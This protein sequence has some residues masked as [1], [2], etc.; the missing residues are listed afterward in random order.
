M[1][2]GILS[3]WASSHTYPLLSEA[4]AV[5]KLTKMGHFIPVSS[6]ASP[7]QTAQLHFQHWWKL[8]GV[9]QNYGLREGSPFKPALPTSATHQAL[10]TAYNP[11]TDGRTERMTRILEDMLHMYIKLVQTDWVETPGCAKYAINNRDQK[12]TNSS[13]FF[14]S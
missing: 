10:S 8:H 7:E 14:L 6:S 5:D 12:S 1:F 13:Y 2:C 9:S 4:V 11:Q 3:P